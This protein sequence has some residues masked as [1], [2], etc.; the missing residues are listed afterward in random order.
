M[1][2]LVVFAS[3]LREV[4]DG[5]PGVQNL[6]SEWY[7][8]ASPSSAFLTASDDSSRRL[9]KVNR[10]GRARLLAG[11]HD[12][13]VARNRFTGP[14]PWRADAPLRCAG[15]RRNTSP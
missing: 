3:D 9:P 7:A 10:V 14:R 8:R 13:A 12:L 15:R 1:G 6:Q 11:R 4:G 2:S 5:G